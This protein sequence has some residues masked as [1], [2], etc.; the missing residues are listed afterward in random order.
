V[1]LYVDSAVW[2]AAADRGDRSNAKAK[3]VLASGERLVTSD[4][5]LLESWLLICHR[6]NHSAAERF[7]DALRR[8]AAMIEAV[9]LADLEAAWG[10]GLAFKDQPFSLTDRTSF[11]IMQRLG[12][13]RVAT[14]DRDFA[15]CRYGPGRRKSFTIVD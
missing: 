15:V 9:T 7:W 5:V 3:R 11:A 14:L 2:Y 1:S 10:I 4:H 13:D 12:I 6:S 8:G